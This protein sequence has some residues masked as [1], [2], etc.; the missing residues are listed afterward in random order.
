MVEDRSPR[1]RRERVIVVHE[2]AQARLPGCPRRYT[3][4]QWCRYLAA[5]IGTLEDTS[6]EERQCGQ[7]SLTDALLAVRR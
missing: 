7:A 3:A 4:P 6:A 2:F 1:Y 5:P